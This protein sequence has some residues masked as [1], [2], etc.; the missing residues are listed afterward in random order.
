[1]ELE[2]L[3]DGRVCGRGFVKQDHQGPAPGT[4]HEGIILAALSEAMSFACGP[5]MGAARVEL[6]V[7]APVPVGA[8]VDVEAHAAEESR[9]RMKAS[10]D[11]RVEGRPV[12]TA[13]GVYTRR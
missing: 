6:E 1:M 3:A 8:F 5:E 12:A 11:A 7:T 2:L 13:R 10:A 4:A 9:E